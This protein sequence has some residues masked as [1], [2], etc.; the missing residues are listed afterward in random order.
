MQPALQVGKFSQEQRQQWITEGLELVRRTAFRLARR[1]PAHIDVGDLIGAGTEGLLRAIDDFDSSRGTRFEAYASARIKGTM[2]DELR[3]AD[4]FTRY[5]RQKFGEVRRAIRK[6][7]AE[8][9]TS[10]TEE[11]IAKALGLSLEAYYRLAENLARGAALTL[12]SDDDPDAVHDAAADVDEGILQKELREQL[13]QAITR[14]P[15]RSQQVLALYYQ[16]ECTQAEIGEILGVSESRVCQILGES[17]ARLG[18]QLKREPL[19]RQPK[20]A[21]KDVGMEA[22]HG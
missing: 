5:G 7:E 20:R 19:K 10:P 15:E 6:L 17:F 16:E 21:R 4:N 13:A 2:L 12:M 11:E 9:G 3:S 14:L 8:L 18:A 22:K 1:L